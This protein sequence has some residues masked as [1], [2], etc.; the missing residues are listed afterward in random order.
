MPKYFYT[1]KNITTGETS[2]GEMEAKDERALAQDLRARGILLTSHKEAKEKESFNI[3]FFDRFVSVPLKEKMIFTRNMSV[4]ISSGL[5]VSRAVHNLS[6]QTRNKKFKK[7]LLSVYDSLQTG[8]SMSEG[9]AQYPGVFNELFV[10]MIAV[11]EV[12]GNLEEVLGILA[13]QLEK[14]HELLSIQR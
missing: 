8:K 11:G 10:N 5:S 1:A 12:S 7:I 13:L 6:V 4:M 9:L 14:E 3:K 2:G